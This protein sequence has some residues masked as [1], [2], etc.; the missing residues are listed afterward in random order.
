[1]NERM[2][3][4]D[5][6]ERL[7][8]LVEKNKQIIKDLEDGKLTTQEASDRVNQLSI[9]IKELTSGKGGDGVKCN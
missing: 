3:G 1:M 4:S 6:S 2:K 7:K 9:E 5:Y 8:L